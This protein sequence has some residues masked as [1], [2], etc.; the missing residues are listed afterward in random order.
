MSNLTINTTDNQI[1]ITPSATEIRLYPGGFAVAGGNTTELQYNNNGILA[2]SANITYTNGN[3]VV[4]NNNL[5]IAGGT[6]GYFLQTDG[7]GNLTWYPGTAFPTGNG[8]VGGANTQIQYNNA[9]NFGGIAGFTVN[10][11]NNNISVPNN[12][13]VV[14]N[15]NVSGITA[16]GNV[17]ANY[18]IG[19]GALLT[20]ITTVT[21]RIENGNSNVRVFANS[22]V[23]VSI[24]GF[25]N[26]LRIS[27]SNSTISTAYDMNVSGGITATNFYGGGANLSN[28]TGANVT[29]QVGNALIAGTVYTNAQPNITSVGT[30]SSLSVSGN[31]NISSINLVKYQETLS[32]ANVSGTITPD[33]ATST[34]FEYTLTGN[35]T[36]NSLANAVSGTSVTMLLKQDAV[37]NRI[38]TSN[39]KFA[40]NVRNLSTAANSQD[41]L[42]IV[43]IGSTYYAALTKGYV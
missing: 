18:F 6:N 19:N 41:V 42:C 11:T 20:G 39:M 1:N 25:A 22:D 35:I 2:G 40:G 28:I 34:I 12:L 9:G 21:D 23:T 24:G 13:S 31:A 17:T 29:G 27:G 3:M 37:G 38:L 4:S 8:T 43:L 14:S 15:I 33:V 32:T 7:S 30:L 36:L 10:N 26:I 16:T 5:K